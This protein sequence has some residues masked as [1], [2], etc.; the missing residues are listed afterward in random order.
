MINVL[1]HLLEVTLGSSPVG[2]KE[3]QAK[4]EAKGKKPGDEVQGQDVDQKSSPS[5]FRSNWR[6][7]RR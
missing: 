3:T 4:F 7:C 5:S 1:K 6:F 2:Y